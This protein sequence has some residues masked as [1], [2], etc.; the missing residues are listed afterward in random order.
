MSVGGRDRAIC[1][2]AVEPH[3]RDQQ[4]I[5]GSSAQLAVLAP[6]PMH[7][8]DM[9]TVEFT[10]SGEPMAQLEEGTL[11]APARQERANTMLVA[12]TVIT[13]DIKFA[14]SCEPVSHEEIPVWPCLH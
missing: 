6:S 14:P 11:D 4:R 2:W 12:L 1:Q 8:I 7:I 13:S 10:G 9:Q 3:G 5:P